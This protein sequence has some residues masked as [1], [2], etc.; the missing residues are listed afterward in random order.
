MSRLGKT[1][2]A[3][4]SGVTCS[5]SGRTFKAEG[6][7]GKL[8]LDV[9]ADITVNIEE[10][11]IVLTRPS[12]EKQHKAF[13]GLARSLVSNLVEGV[14]K[15]FVKEL[16]IHGVG[17]NAKAEGKNL[18]MNLGYNA[19]VK[20]PVPEGLTVETPS[21]TE[22]KISGIDKQLVG[23]F[24]ANVR[25]KR[26]PE[27]YKQ[28]GIRY[29]GPTSRRGSGTRV[30]TC[31]RRPV[32]HSSPARKEWIELWRIGNRHTLVERVAKSACGARFSAV[33]RSR[34]CPCFAATSISTCS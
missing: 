8:E 17:Y 25:V 12:D 3:I 21:N 33:R 26:P 24:A 15:G 16:E 19:P 13:H 1:P 10:K 27:P 30:K 9:P 34:A 4:P 32:R 22:I 6:P 31:R 11:E 29:K 5:L 2:V 23:Q 7:K 18:V 20:M 28:K 14:S